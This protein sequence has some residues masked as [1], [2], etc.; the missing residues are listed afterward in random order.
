VKIP[1]SGDPVDCHASS[2][3]GTQHRLGGRGQSRELVPAADGHRNCYAHIGT[4]SDG[5]Q[6]APAQ[7]A[8]MVLSILRASTAQDCDLAIDRYPGLTLNG[9]VGH[10]LAGLARGA[11]PTA[12]SVGQSHAR[13]GP[14][15]PDRS[16]MVG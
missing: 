15:E 11:G 3:E 6:V 7:I 14:N 4:V 9:V 16:K 8:G 1:R 10:I 5:A 13:D 2:V 12:T